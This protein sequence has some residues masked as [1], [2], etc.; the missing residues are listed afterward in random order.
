[1]GVSR[2]LE[3]WGIPKSEI[4]EFD[5]WDNANYNGIQ[6]TFTPSR[7]FSGRGLKDRAKSL[8]GGWV[9]KSAN[10]N[11]YW[12]GDGGYGEHF[13][14]IGEKFGPFDFGFI[15]CGQY[16]EHWHQ[17]H[18]YPE[19]AVQAAIDSQVKKMMPV[20]WGAFAL[21]L[22]S[23]HD[24]IQRAQQ[25]AKKLGVELVTPSLGQSISLQ[26]EYSQNHWWLDYMED[27][28]LT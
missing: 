26:E 17:I 21:A 2:H 6:F 27:L 22:H 9:M 14:D 10:H 3:S 8:W 11:L 13:K 18:M 28:T 15:E 24:S 1:L 19:E 4:Q 5:W 16:N 25:E 12:S 20:H 7:H 23:W